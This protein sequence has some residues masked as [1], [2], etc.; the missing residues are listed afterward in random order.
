MD[1]GGT[2][3]IDHWSGTFRVASGDVRSSD[4]GRDHDTASA[5]FVLRHSFA[6][7]H[8]AVVEPIERWFRATR[9]DAYPLGSRAFQPR[10][11]G[12][13]G[14]SPSVGAWERTRM[15]AWEAFETAVKSGALGITRVE[16]QPVFVTPVQP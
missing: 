8:S 1:K 7:H 5:L 14:A 15:Q 12:A 4:T 13:F 3:N 9:G 10:A 11:G 16:H 6:N 2:F